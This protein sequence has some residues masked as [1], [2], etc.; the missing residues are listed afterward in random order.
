MNILLIRLRLIGDVVL[1]TPSI[2]ALRRRYPAARLTYLVEPEAAPVVL[3]NPHLDHVVVATGPADRGRMRSDVALARRLRAS[4]FDLVI[5]FHGGPRSSWLTRVTG[6]TARIGY[7][8]RGRGWMYTVRVPRPRDLRPRHSVINQ[9]DLLAPLGFSPPDPTRDATEMPEDPA[10]AARVIASLERA[11]VIPGQHAVIA[12]H[13][14]AG[15][16]FRRWP[17]PSFVRLVAALV[18]ADPRRRVVL[19]SGPSE[20]DAAA[21]IGHD[22]RQ[23]LGPA[24]AGAVVFET[25]FNLA[26]LRALLGRADLFIGGDSGPLHV[27]SATAVPIVG[28]FGPTLSARSAPWRSP[29]LVTESIEL[30]E[31]PCRPCDQR[32]CGPGD[33]R[34]LAWIEPETVRAAAERALMRSGQ[35]RSASR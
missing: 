19:T 21:R 5:D 14:S 20:A 10:A 35:R 7:A 1:T 24:L 18:E 9:W 29:E 31:L 15:N 25:A 22:A 26:E 6:A 34:C 32:R 4:R 3:P 27:A 8:V 23:Q 30:T 12:L 33:F 13:V 11:D 28:L 2:R 16:P 17:V